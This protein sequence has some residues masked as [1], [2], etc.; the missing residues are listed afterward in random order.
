MHRA[1]G[2]AAR[3]FRLAAGG[4]ERRVELIVGELGWVPVRFESRDRESG[5]LQVREHVPRLP[6]GLDP[7]SV[8]VEGEHDRDVVGSGGRGDGR[9]M[10]PESWTRRWRGLCVATEGVRNEHT[11]HAA[12]P[13]P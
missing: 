5:G 1:P 3:R 9:P 4:G 6:P 8:A 13:P 2:L 7:G 11:L 10:R 12:R